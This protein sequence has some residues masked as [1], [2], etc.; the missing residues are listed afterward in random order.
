MTFWLLLVQAL[1]FFLPVYFANMAPQFLSKIPYFSWPIWEKK[2]GKHKTWRGL[3]AA[4]LMGVFVFW[5]QKYLFQ[6]SF[7][8][9]ISLIDYGGFSL[10]LGFLLGLGAILGDAVKSYYKRKS[11]IIPGESWK[12]WD[13]LDFVI[14][15]LVLSLL[16]YVP[17]FEVILIILIVSPF[18]HILFS[19]FG[20][21]LKIKEEKF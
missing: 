7:F 20:Y 8:N 5:L 11:G 2:L 19:R 14:G 18:L 16:I 3:V 6:F 9:K 21:W 4:T 17:R 13:Q 10:W 12:P 15:G 1:Y